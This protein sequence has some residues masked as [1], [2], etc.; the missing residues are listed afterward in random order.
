MQLLESPLETRLSNNNNINNNKNLNIWIFF[1]HAKGKKVKCVGGCQREG[2]SL[3]SSP[4]PGPET[5]PGGGLAGKGGPHPAAS[6][7]G[8]GGVAGRGQLDGP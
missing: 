1:G 4:P 7:Q 2:A 8:V 5:G 3:V 6:G